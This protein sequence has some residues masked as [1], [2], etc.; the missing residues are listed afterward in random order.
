VMRMFPL[1]GFTESPAIR[2]VLARNAQSAAR[3]M[4]DTTAPLF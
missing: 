3:K 2:P 4:G 1:P